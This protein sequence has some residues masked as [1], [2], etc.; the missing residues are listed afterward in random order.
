MVL[1][2]LTLRGGERVEAVVV[3]A[4]AAGQKNQGLAGNARGLGLAFTSH[5]WGT[6][7]LL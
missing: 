1:I 5:V 6:I 3:V 2:L 7:I 4:A